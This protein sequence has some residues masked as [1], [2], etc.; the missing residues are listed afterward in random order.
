MN[1]DKAKTNSNEA[2]EKLATKR[3]ILRKMDQYKIPNSLRLTIG[4]EAANEH[5]IK[6]INEICK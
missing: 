4:N 3:L 1:F 6:S 2:F 5:F